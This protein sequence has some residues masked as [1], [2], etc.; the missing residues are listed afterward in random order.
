MFF[1]KKYILDFYKQ[2]V[3]PWQDIG[4]SVASFLAHVASVFVVLTFTL[5]QVFNVSDEMMGSINKLYMSCWWFYV[6]DR[7]SH[8]L[9]RKGAYWK[10]R[11][12]MAGRIINILLLVTLIPLFFRLVGTD[13]SSNLVLALIDRFGIWILF[14]VSL[15][16]CFDF[17]TRGLGKKTNPS[18][19]LALSFLC[20]ILFGSGVLLMPGCLTPHANITW[21]DTLFT[22]T[23]AVCVTGLS[24]VDITEQFT[25]TGQC[26]IIFLVQ[27]G[28]LGVM[29]ITSFFALF[30]MGNISLYSQM[31]V[32][33]MVNAKSLDN[34][35]SL[36]KNVLGF[37]LFIELVGAVC[38]FISI[39]HHFT[40]MTFIDEV[41]FCIFH[42]ISAF[43][44]A[45]FSSLP[46]GLSNPQV[47]NHLSLY[48]IV[49]F[50]IVLGSIG[51]PILMNFRGIIYKHLQIVWRKM[52][53]RHYVSQ[54]IPHLF[55]LNTKIVLQATL[56]FIIVG[57]LFVSFIEWKGA[58]HSLS[59]MAKITHAFFTAVCPRT[60]GFESID[61][62]VLAPT[63]LMVYVVFMWIGGASQST[64]GGV[65]LNTF[66]TAMLNLRT[67]IRGDEHIEIYNR[68]IPL[69]SVRRANATILASL[70]CLGTSI[71]L[72]EWLEPDLS[73]K[74]VSFECISAL[75]TVGSS[76]GI[77][78]D[79]HLGG[80]IL[81]MILMFVG[82]V[83]T[84]TLAQGMI[85]NQMKKHY[86]LPEEN[87][88]IS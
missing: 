8:L 30:F 33:D 70:L 27:I 50:I 81:I 62:N 47:M 41:Y 1:D 72:M 57:T 53:G 23:S 69:D 34:L 4:L 43:C 63:T 16:D 48:W 66:V 61:L 5:E 83:G 32:R 73:L 6:I 18:M 71:F 21:V 77:T 82:R 84:I 79:L 10:E 56:A 28:G 85:S 86:K 49:G 55:D 65:K 64:A 3:L 44:N 67:I 9:V 37:T 14:S 68:Q 59:P 87:I 15:L 25:R 38:I 19:I 74:E 58:M 76:L 45:G 46:L 54:S 40:G 35:T 52:H 2:S 20:L 88:I 39:H 26:V 11:F 17:M 78:S 7:G 75:G 51:Y 36:L 13:I 60:A 42:S 80:K 12:E 22:A 29:T 24:T 31:V